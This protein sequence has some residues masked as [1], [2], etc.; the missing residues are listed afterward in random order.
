MRS[1][2]TW[3]D[4]ELPLLVGEEAESRFGVKTAFSK[5]LGGVSSEPFDSLDMSPFIGDDPAAVAR[6]HEL[7]R[8]AFS[9]T[10]LKFVKQVHGDGVLDAGFADPVPGE[11]CV[12]GEGDAL[13]AER[14]EAGAV[15]V[16][17]ADCVPIL[18]AGEDRIAAVHA[19]WRG[20][21]AGVIGRAAE[22]VGRVHAAWVGPSIRGCCYEVGAEVI[23]AFR[24]N[25]LPLT[26]DTHVDPG[27]AAAVLLRRAGIDEVVASWECTHCDESF[28]SYRRDGKTGR[29]AAA[30]AW[31]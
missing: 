16:L 14:D 19:G 25:D 1:G 11:P 5:R 9:V 12:L 4:G 24:S 13:V 29:Q 28:Y 17:T 26:D 18:L 22:A 10:S 15:V 21:V 31:S 7:F 8:E 6:N 23:E 30:I 3:T 2:L 27:K 20:L